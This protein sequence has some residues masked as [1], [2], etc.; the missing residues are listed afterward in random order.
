V[1][2]IVTAAVLLVE[3]LPNA[4]LNA[5]AAP[6]EAEPAEQNLAIIVNQSNPV[7]NVSFR[8]CARSFLGNA[9]TGQTAGALHLSCWSPVNPNAR[10]F[11][12]RFT[13]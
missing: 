9:V 13:G 1:L 8:I 5:A 3:L 6:P 2:I 7:D 4:A 11:F 10:R 12:G